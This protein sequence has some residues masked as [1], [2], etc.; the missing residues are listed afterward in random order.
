MAARAKGPVPEWLGGA[1]VWLAVL[2]GYLGWSWW[3][4]LWMAVLIA[5]LF[6]SY[7]PRRIAIGHGR[8]AFGIGL[9][10][11]IFAPLFIA[12]V[13]FAVGRMAAPTF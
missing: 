4:I 8:Q 11:A 7:R 9:L 5:A 6:L 13:L 10:V 1:L 2:P 3:H 12:T